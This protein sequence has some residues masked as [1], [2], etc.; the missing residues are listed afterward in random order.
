M[1]QR[2]PI[3]L[4]DGQTTP[5]NVTFSPDN[6]PVGEVSF[7]DKSTGVAAFFRR[8]VV[9]YSAISSQRKTTRTQYEVHLPVTGTVDGVTK[10]IRTLRAKVEFVL[11]DETTDAERKDLHAFVVN[12]L[13]NTLVRG[14]MRDLDPIY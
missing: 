6:S 11:P 9:K 13:G 3:V 12:G 2:A 7:S 8:I 4:A 5:A 10:V 14:N 1:A